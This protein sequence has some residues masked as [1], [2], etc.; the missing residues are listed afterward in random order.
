M[1]TKA[2]GVV[3]KYL[4]KQTEMDFHIILPFWVGAEAFSIQKYSFCSIPK[5]GT[6]Q[7]AVKLCPYLTLILWQK[8]KGQ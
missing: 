1:Q 2:D 4:Q 6:E 8:R 7:S 5:L 3:V